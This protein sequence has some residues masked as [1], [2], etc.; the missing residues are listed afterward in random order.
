MRRY[1]AIM[2]GAGVM[3]IA[4]VALGGS[5][6]SAHAV[7][8]K[9]SKITFS[10]PAPVDPIHTFGEPSINFNGPRNELFASGPTGT[11]TQRSEW[12]A[13]AD[14]GHTF[15][16]INPG[17]VPTAI[18]SSPGPKPGGGDTDINHDRSGKEYFID[19]YALACDR[20]ATTSDGGATAKQSFNGCGGHLGSDRQW[21]AV[22]DPP[23][24]TPHKSKYHGPTPLVYE[25]YNNLVGNGGNGDAQWNRSTDGL[26][27]T[28]AT[29][30]VTPANEVV[31]SPFGSDGYP[32]IDQQT[33]KV[34]EAAGRSTG[35]TFA[36]DLN[37]GTPDAQGN[38]TFLDRPTSSGG[39]PNTAGLIP[40]ATNLPASP[41]TL[42]SVLSMD[43]ARNLFVVYA[44][45]SSSKPKLDQVWVSA[46]SAASGWKKWTK[47]VMVSDGRTATGDAV[48]IFPWI[49][50]GGPGRADAV[51]YGA[52]KASDPST[53][54]HQRWNVFMD[55][56][57]FPVNSH[58]GIT[59]A[60]PRKT[61][62]KV[63]PHPMKYNEV[64][65]EGTGCIASQ[66][67]RNLADFFSVDIDKQGA[68]EIV[69]DDTSNGLVQPG[70]TPGNQQFLDHAGA[71]LV[72]LAHQASGMGLYGKPVKGPSHKP[73][74]GINDSAGDA[75]YPVIGGKNLPGLDI[76]GSSLEVS[77]NGRTLTI[78]ISVANLKDASATAAK[79]PGT[80][81]LEY[82][83]RWQLGKTLWYAGMST[84]PSGSKSFYSGKS[85]S[86]DLCSV[87]ACF[88][89]VL[90]YPESGSGGTSRQGKVSCPPH[91][92][93]KTPC[94]ITIAVSA[95][96]VGLPKSPSRDIGGVLSHARVLQEVG[97]YA[98]ATSH[99]QGVTTNAQAQADSVPL[100]I[101][102]LCCFNF[103]ASPQVAHKPPPKKHHHHHHQ[104]HH[105]HHRHHRHHHRHHH[106]SR[107]PRRARGFTG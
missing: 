102:G 6:S 69:Y 81:L 107:R 104:H 46:A 101:D 55:Q 87:S 73:V 41:D 74:T 22:Y 88:P 56:V 47:P 10:V 38:L 97:T 85:Q 32:A 71:P 26:N 11:G 95:Q 57:V 83:T 66:G 43:S 72:T 75:L 96:D 16:L 23:P 76:L 49:K 68:A 59:G 80:Q 17:G 86:V 34:F 90:T 94:T 15:R 2:T 29:T 103:S 93:A 18:Q 98:F 77:S 50:A 92:S 21:L 100:Q 60:P 19:L 9:A 106:P 1:L 99:P 63:T 35:K 105:Q 27:F 7:A 12:E 78:K 48:N 70:F 89:H 51:W 65:L 37:I 45:N 4:L 84:S 20:T 36:M 14:G 25:E 67:N 62:V 44:V 61:L 54:A 52:D 40:I 79:V 8:A 24:G 82:V 31:Y 5:G 28:N 91:P 13:S 39:G 33:G 3:A 42:F 53:P 30:G 58:G 64:C